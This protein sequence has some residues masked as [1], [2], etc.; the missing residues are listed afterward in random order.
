MSPAPVPCPL[1]G[2]VDQQLIYDLTR[3]DLA[4]AVPGLV[5][6]CRACPMW[7]KAL[8]RPEALPTAYPGEFGDDAVSA[9]Y[10]LGDAARALFRDAL[11]EARRQVPGQ[12]PRLLDLGTGQGA[13]LEEAA[14]LGFVAEGVDHC[15]DNVERARARGLDVNLATARELDRPGAFDVVTMMDFIEHLPDPLAVLRV[16]HRALRPGGALVVYT[17]NH[18]SGVVLLARLLYAVGVRRPVHELFGRNHVAFFDDRSLPWALVAAGFEL[19][20]L[21]RSAYDPSRPGQDVSRL[22]LAVMGAVEQLGRPFG[23]VFRLLAFARKPA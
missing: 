19:R 16:A 21:Q 5:M 3:L 14:R 2:G 15:A 18:R 12:A 1:C 6:R 8:E 11:A 20:T 7:F 4:D 10:L 23:R 9:T 13:L 17:P 22:T